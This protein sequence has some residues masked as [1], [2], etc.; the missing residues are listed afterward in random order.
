MII[1]IKNQNSMLRK[2]L[3]IFFFLYSFTTYSQSGF[4][5]EKGRSKVTIPFQLINNLIF[6]QVQMNG[7]E[8]TFLLDTGVEETILFSLHEENQVVLNQVEAI[9]L[10]GLGS[11]EAIDGYKSSGNSIKIKHLID[12]NHTV[13]V[14]LD[15]EFNFSSNVGIPV[16][17]ILG[18]HF[19]KNHL[20]EIDYQRKKITVY[21]DNSKIIQKLERK[22]TKDSISIELSKPYVFKKIANKATTQLSK[23]LIDTGNSDAVWI[24]NNQ[25][26]KIPSSDVFFQDFLGR[27]FNGNVYGK[28]SRI[29]EIQF[30]NH[31]FKNVLAS[32]PDSTSTQGVSK[33]VNRVGS[34]GGEILSRFTIVLDYR[35]K[36]IYTKQNIS[37]DNP[38][39]F[40][41]SGIEVEHAGI[42]WK[43]NA[44]QFSSEGNTLSTT[45]DYYSTKKS[46]KQ[47]L[48]SHFSLLPIF[49][50][51]SVRPNS[52]AAK[53]GLQAQDKI[54]QI[55]NRKSST[56][57]IQKIHDLLKSEEG[58]V[59][60]FVIERNEIK[61]K[62]KIK[63]RK[64][65]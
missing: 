57:T 22:F 44:H 9:K 34:V 59:I 27:G 30:G 54:I 45:S 1:F 23:L 28:R 52:E 39:N 12:A 7:E 46:G 4:Q 20:V 60:N 51:T 16:N 3:F 29:D 21:P 31:R 35:N 33:V 26:G 56:L 36:A 41:M 15:S 48:K 17:G 5:I 38:F 2:L 40:N 63:L 53:V 11:S 10:K 43:Q 24:F 58:K 37:I 32:F 19:F 62:F 25:K 6:I 50:I 18:Y 61:Y 55:N 47:N 65:L 8:L 49:K 13:Y 64:M 42:E 14:V